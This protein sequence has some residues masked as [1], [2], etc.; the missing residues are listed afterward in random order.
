MYI[1]IYI[2]KYIYKRYSRKKQKQII[3]GNISAT[4]FINT[5][6]STS[7]FSLMIHFK[8]NVQSIIYMNEPENSGHYFLKKTLFYELFKTLSWNI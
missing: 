4:A 2:Y 7:H 1:Y 5:F 3:I 6:L 8:T